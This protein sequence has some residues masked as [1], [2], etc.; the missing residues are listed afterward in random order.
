MYMFRFCRIIEDCNRQYLV[1]AANNTLLV[2]KGEVPGPTCALVIDTWLPELYRPGW[3]TAR[4]VLY[5]PTDAAVL[6]ALECFGTQHARE[7]YY[8]L[9]AT[10]TNQLTREEQAAAQKQLTFSVGLAILE[11]Y[12]AIA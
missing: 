10:Q 12:G 8:L 9:V 5:L 6:Q 3:V 2:G 7:V 11:R 1:R 4:T